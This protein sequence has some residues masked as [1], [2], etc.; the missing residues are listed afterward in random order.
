MEVRIADPCVFV[1]TA[2]RTRPSST[3]RSSGRSFDSHHAGEFH[4]SPLRELDYLVII[5]FLVDPPMG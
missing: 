5:Q 3:A 4:L 1:P 2:T